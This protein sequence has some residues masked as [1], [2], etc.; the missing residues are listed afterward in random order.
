M[1]ITDAE[2]IEILERSRNW[3]NEILEQTSDQ[4]REI[5]STY[6]ELVKVGVK[7]ED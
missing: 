2:V 7:N 4:F 5:R 1:P 6:I 3:S